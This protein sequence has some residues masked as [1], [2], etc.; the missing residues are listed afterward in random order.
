MKF[1]LPSLF[2]EPIP[3][4]E[5]D[6]KRSQASIAEKGG[7]DGVTDKEIDDSEFQKGVQSVQASSQVWSRNHLILAYAM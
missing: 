2:P 7:N 6:E 4:V 3:V 1:R 5:E